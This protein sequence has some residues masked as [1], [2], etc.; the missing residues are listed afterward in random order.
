MCDVKS[1]QVSILILFL[2]QQGF[3]S[4]VHLT[5]SVFSVAEHKLELD[6]MAVWWSG[7]L[8][9]GDN[10]RMRSRFARAPGNAVEK[11]W[12]LTRT[13]LVSCSWWASS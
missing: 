13:G 11:T 6:E 8:S 9:S 10:F 2:R 5:G 1:D 12:S 3:H 4:L 7:M